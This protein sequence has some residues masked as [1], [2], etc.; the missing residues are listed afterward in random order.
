[1]PGP[2]LFAEKALPASAVDDNSHIRDAPRDVDRVALELIF[3][4]EQVRDRNPHQDP[5][6][7]CGAHRGWANSRLPGTSSCSSACIFIHSL[8][9]RASQMRQGPPTS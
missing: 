8:R 4:I 7:G 3:E 2:G 1:M 9:K 6:I 5:S